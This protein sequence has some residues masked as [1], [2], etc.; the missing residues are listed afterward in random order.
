MPGGTARPGPPDRLRRA[1][2]APLAAF[3]VEGRALL[4]A[5]RDSKGRALGGTARPGSDA[6][7]NREAAARRRA[8]SIGPPPAMAT[9]AASAVPGAKTGPCRDFTRTHALWRNQK[10]ALH[11]KDLSGSVQP[12]PGRQNDRPKRLHNA[13]NGTRATK[14]E[15]VGRRGDENAGRPPGGQPG[16]RSLGAGGPGAGARG[17]AGRGPALGGRRVGGRRSGTGGPGTAEDEAGRAGT[18]EAG[19]GRPVAPGP[20]SPKSRWPGRLTARQTP[21]ATG[22][23]ARKGRP[24]GCVVC[25]GDATADKRP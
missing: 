18:P 12:R 24:T 20:D 13:K 17:P 1:P 7:L 5:V 23:E 6:S 10:A 11:P 22:R 2:L 4:S 16:R 25:A 19:A 14:R 9:S 3:P 21:R 15:D 8:A